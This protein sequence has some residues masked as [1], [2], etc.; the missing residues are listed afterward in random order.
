MRPYWSLWVPRASYVSNVSMQVN[1]C[2]YGSL[3]VLIGPYA[4][5]C[6]KWVLM[7]RYESL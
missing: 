3:W 6:V 1:M 7:R 2:L 4:S 5:L